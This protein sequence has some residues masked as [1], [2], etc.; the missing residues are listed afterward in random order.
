MKLYHHPMS[1]SARRVALT[2]SQLGIDVEHRLIDLR[3]ADDRAALVA[4]N[5]NNKIPVLVD[6]DFV[7]WESHAIMAYLCAKAPG[8]TLYPEASRARAD[9]DRWLHWTA[10]HLAP[11]VGSIS[12]EKLWKKMMGGGDADPAIVARHEVFLRAAAKVL[13]AHLERRQW[14]VGDSLTLAD[15]SIVSTLMYRKPTALPL[16]EYSNVLALVARVEALPAW[17]STEASRLV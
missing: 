2:V 7:L 4:V 16:E 12:F 14:V 11:A 1:S 15:F 6:D 10:S 5:P 9:V 13:D 17:Q 8:Q 3:S